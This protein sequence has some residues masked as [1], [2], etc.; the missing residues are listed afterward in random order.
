MFTL[1][2]RRQK[3]FPLERAVLFSLGL[4]VIL[5]FLFLLAPPRREA[6]DPRKGLLAAFVPPEDEQVRIPVKFMEAPG[7]RRENPKRRAFSDLD[8]R[9]GGGDPSRPRGSVPYA[10][11]APGVAGMRPGSS[12]PGESDGRPLRGEEGTETSSGSERPPDVEDAAE[13]PFARERRSSQRGAGA[14]TGLDEAI[15]EAAEAGAG[16]EGAGFPNPEG[17]FVDS[18]PISFDTTWYD[19]GPYAAEMVRRIKLHWEIP[20]LARLGWK[21][22]LTVR[23]FILADGRV[24]GAT[25]IS[26]SGVPPFD[27]AALQA[28]LKS[29]PF[30]PL[31]SDL[32]SNREGVT[33]T[34]FYNMRPNRSGEPEP[35]R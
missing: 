24:E 1:E 35:S 26:R 28:I 17:G 10:P 29:S 12:G 4:H 34:F 14:L 11:P 9:S 30:R 13:S 31:P 22:K 5:F 2:E 21:G 25:I 19:W 23:F 3:T 8:R 18:G 33:V 20:S 15:R 32:G 7:P 27:F 6:P 16:G